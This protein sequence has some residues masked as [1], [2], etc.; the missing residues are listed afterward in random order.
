MS[1]SFYILFFVILNA[2][3]SDARGGGLFLSSFFGKKSSNIEI[4]FHKSV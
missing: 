2:L 4:L 3:E 1:S